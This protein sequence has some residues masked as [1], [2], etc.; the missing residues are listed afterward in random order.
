MSACKIVE[1]LNYLHTLAM[2]ESNPIRKKALVNLSNSLNS[3]RVEIRQEAA[4]A[5]VVPFSDSQTAAR[6]TQTTKS[7][8]EETQITKKPAKVG[9]RTTTTKPVTKSS[10]KNGRDY[11][12]YARA[13]LDFVKKQTAVKV[14]MDLD[15]A[16]DLL[17]NRS[18]S[19]ATQYTWKN[20]IQYPDFSGLI[21]NKALMRKLAEDRKNGETVQDIENLANG[22]L[23]NFHMDMTKVHEHVHAGSVA[24]MERY[25]YD[26][27][28]KYVHTLFAR[29][30]KLAKKN[31]NLANIQDGYWMKNHK[32]FVA[33]ALSN[34]DMMKYLNRIKIKGAP[35]VSRFT[36]LINKLAEMAGLKVDSEGYALAQIF[37]E[38]AEQ[39]G[40]I[41][42]EADS[43][44]LDQY[45]AQMLVST[46]A[47]QQII[48]KVD[49]CVG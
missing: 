14:V 3:N 9:K 42:Q 43:L 4:F 37:I 10:T 15:L 32:E 33:V 7:V 8:V 18:D 5:G 45:T 6:E 26:E 38:M 23:R 29:I 12:G 35:R 24:F 41:I 11:G 22:H 16:V 17:M 49:E 44:D 47:I 13:L 48:N 46:A 40:A 31:K 20:Y 1:T 19:Y 2:S 30:K 25:P 34:P 28:T 27:K 21:K 36:Q 39:T